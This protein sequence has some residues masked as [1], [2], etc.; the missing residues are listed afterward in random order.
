MRKNGTNAHL[1]YKLHTTSPLP[2]HNITVA[3]SCRRY[4]KNCMKRL[5]TPS[6]TII[7][8][9]VIHAIFLQ[10][11]LLLIWFGVCGCGND[12]IQIRIV[13]AC[14]SICPEVRCLDFCVPACVCSTVPFSLACLADLM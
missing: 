10:T 8:W 12:K 2:I 13:E 3:Y 11:A 6:L 7:I 5:K 9:Q 4:H 14:W 1:I